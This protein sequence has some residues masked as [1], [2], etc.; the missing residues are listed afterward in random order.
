MTLTPA[1]ILGP[2]GRIAARLRHYERRPQQLAMAEA[3]A[4]AIASQ[5]HLVVEAGTGVGKSFAYLVPAI[6]ATIPPTPEKKPP[7]GKPP[8]RRRVVV[9]T[10][11]I[12]LQEQL[13]H[14]DLPLLNAV[15]PD[16]F[17][18]VLVKGRGNYVSL[19]RLEGAL[20]RAGSLFHDPEEFSELRYIDRWSRETTDGS[21]SDLDRRPL[22][23]VWDEARS[24]QGNCM[25][26]QCP[27]YNKCFY[28]ASRRRMQHSQILLVNHAL[29]FSDLAL[30][31][32]DV[33][34]LPD[35]DVAIFDEA[36]TIEAVAGD[37][38]GMKVSS[39]QVE[40]TLNKLYN[41]RTIRGLLV[42]YHDREAEELVG[43][44][45]VRSDEFFET[46]RLWQAASGRRNGRV[47]RAGVVENALSPALVKL[48]RRLRA[49]GEKLESAE[50]RQ[51]FS[52][53]HDRLSV[54]AGEIEQWRTQNMP[55]S[56][57]WL[58]ATH[59][60]RPKTVLAAAPVDVGP[61]LRKQL[62]EVVPSVI[63]TSATLAVGKAGSFDF[64]KS[65]LGLTQVATLSVGS[66]F[67]YRE[68]ATLVLV[69]G[70]P[71]P[72]GEPREFQRQAMKMVRR[73]VARTDGHAFVLF[74]SYEMLRQA[75]A[76]LTP[77]LAERN[78]ALHAQS[79]GLPRTQMLERFKAN[80][81]AVLLG[82]DSFWQGVDV[83]GD[84]LQ[85]VIIT[86]LPFAVPDQPLLEARL[87]AIRESGGNPFS[88]YQLPAAAIKLKQGFGRL[89]RTQHDR[90]T[91]V[92]LDPRVL[93]KPYGRMFLDSLPDCRR[94]RERVDAGEP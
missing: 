65:R 8:K 9:S 80:P 74:T 15:I 70:M 50:V 37:H 45:R 77:W 73:F 67:N 24:E 16:E 72:T 42:H 13:L 59:G 62:F 14:K 86:K 76:D 68:Q 30:R 56:V 20:S 92:I 58:E 17:T 48:A 40:Y 93:T 71:D 64:F 53:A 5:R 23:A 4:K 26:R 36:H 89:I 33:S 19:R 43:D 78:L 11:T 47:D 75:A 27:T 28:F 7:D 18:A 21:L 61:V 34:I 55:A 90:G 83:P 3:V 94:V 49:L 2:E 54:L 12:S 29:F 88:E 81:R 32:H 60:R 41:D 69:E 31:Q 35:Y 1:E 25:G 84:A 85:T 63:M 79:D 57:Y 39:S 38:L 51:D 91:V 6:L 82:T 52:S 66:P 44:C 22:G 46:L 87:D 10:H